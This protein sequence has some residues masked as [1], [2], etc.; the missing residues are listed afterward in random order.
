[1][2]KLLLSILALVAVSAVQAQN[3]NMYIEV[4]PTTDLKNI[5]VTLY[6]TNDVEIIGLRPASGAHR[7]GFAV[8]L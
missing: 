8:L 5:P 2:K 3:V 1:M 6:L 7:L 4:E